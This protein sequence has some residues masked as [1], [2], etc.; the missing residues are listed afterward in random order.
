MDIKTIV[1]DFTK[2]LSGLIEGQ[3]M[4]RARTTVLSA[5]GGPARRGPGRPPKNALAAPKATK[6]ARPRKKPPLQL[7][8]VPGCTNPAA[9]VFGM[10]CAKHKDVAKSKI[11]KYREARKAKTQ[12]VKVVERRMPNRR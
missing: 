10:V 12:G 3:A 7:C 9:P 5:L 2:R 1:A 11:K 4:D 6:V 8:P